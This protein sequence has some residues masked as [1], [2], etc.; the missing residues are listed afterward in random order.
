MAE[1]KRPLRKWEGAVEKQI[2]EAMERGEFRG[3]AGKGKRL[4]LEENPFTPA[5]CRL[6]YKLLQDAG[7]APEWIEQDKAIRR[8]QQALLRMLQDHAIWEREKRT[9]IGTLAPEQ[10]I[11][12]YEDIARSRE[13]M[14][15]RFRER[16]FALNR[17][18]DAFNLT[19]PSSR[20]HYPRIRVQEELDNLQAACRRKS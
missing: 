16:A 6:A 8:D 14:I 2:R 10:L 17:L 3:L 20:L 9:R 5:D 11:A 4:D 19:A 7:V 12:E 13:R 18:I 15:E 1:E